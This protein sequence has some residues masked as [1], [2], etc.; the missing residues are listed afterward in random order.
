MCGYS[1]EI[2]KEGYN[3]TII[4]VH[5]C[6]IVQNGIITT[7]RIRFQYAVIVTE[8]NIILS[9]SIGD[10]ILDYLERQTVFHKYSNF[11]ISANS[12]CDQTELTNNTKTA[13]I[14]TLT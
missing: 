2:N 8:H 1:F 14:G 7:F 9:T 10:W 11:P 6:T 5:T 4:R 3:L 12:I 13:Q